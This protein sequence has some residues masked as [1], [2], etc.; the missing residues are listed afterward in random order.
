MKK[1]Y[2]RGDMKQLT[3]D[4]QA[5]RL[6]QRINAIR[7][8]TSKRVYDDEVVDKRAKLIEHAKEVQKLT[9]SNT[10]RC[11]HDL[12]GVVTPV[13]EADTPGE[14]DEEMEVIKEE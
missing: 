9:R 11:G 6:L 8:S 14:H 1:A 12:I 5:A 13:R 4:P 3:N 7:S 2:F 10:H